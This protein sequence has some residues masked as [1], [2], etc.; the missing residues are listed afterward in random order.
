M[1]REGYIELQGGKQH[2]LYATILAEAHEKGLQSLTTQLIQIP[3]EDNEYTA[4]VRASVRMKDG[5]V[6]E[7]YG[8]ASPRNCTGKVALA[9]IRMSSTRAKGRALRDAINCGQTMLEEFGDEPD[10]AGDRAAA[11][12]PAPKANGGVTV[13]IVDGCGTILKPAQVTFCEQRL[14]GRL[15]CASHQKEA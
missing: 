2:P 13:C 10:S 3:H 1:A 12:V 6:F 5:S 9:L 8:D 15:L 7:D 4:I 11:V 14:A